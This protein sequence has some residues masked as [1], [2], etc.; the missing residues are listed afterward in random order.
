[1]SFALQI[2]NRFQRKK[3]D[4]PIASTVVVTVILVVAFEAVLGNER[5]ENALLRHAAPRDVDGFES[6]GHRAMIACTP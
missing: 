5:L 3:H 4:G 6:T 1:V 2:A